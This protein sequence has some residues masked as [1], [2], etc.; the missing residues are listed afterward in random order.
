MINGNSPSLF[1][2]VTEIASSATT[3]AV[4]V[5]R[6]Y[7]NVTNDRVSYGVKSIPAVV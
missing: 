6:H 2:V 3:V 7:L 5:V 4:V 1:F